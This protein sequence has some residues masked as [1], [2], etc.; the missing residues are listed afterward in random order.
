MPFMDL[1][2]LANIR[3]EL[4]FFVHRLL[5]G[6]VLSFTFS[7]DIHHVFNEIEAKKLELSLILLAITIPMY[8]IYRCKPRNIFFKRFQSECIQFCQS[9]TSIMIGILIFGISSFI[10]ALFKWNISFENFTTILLYL[11]FLEVFTMIHFDLKNFE[12]DF[13][14]DQ[15]LFTIT[16]TDNGYIINKPPNGK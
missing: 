9:V 15:A 1:I 3:K 13:K 2:T 5:I 14:N 10:Y 11:F 7:T 8:V 12:Y 16:V 6:F 4:R